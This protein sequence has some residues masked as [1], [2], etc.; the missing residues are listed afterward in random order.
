[1][2]TIHPCSFIAVDKEITFQRSQFRE[3]ILQR[4]N[5]PLSTLIYLVPQIRRIS[6]TRLERTRSICWRT[7]RCSAGHKSPLYLS[8]PVSYGPG[9]RDSLSTIKLAHT[10][11]LSSAQ[12]RCGQ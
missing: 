10:D 1:M 12:S 4:P 7:Y 3:T 8:G 6:V 9:A 11:R 5:D 2:H